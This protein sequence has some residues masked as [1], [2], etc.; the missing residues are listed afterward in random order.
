MNLL[1]L[2]FILGTDGLIKFKL[3]G[4]ADANDNGTLDRIAILSKGHAA[5]NSGKVFNGGQGIAHRLAIFFK[6]TG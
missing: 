6:V 2:R 4:I 5:R 3:T 1:R